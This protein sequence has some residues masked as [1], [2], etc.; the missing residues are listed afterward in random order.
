[1]AIEYLTKD[2]VAV[3]VKKTPRQARALMDKVGVT[4]ACGRVLVRRDALDR[5]LAEQND[6]KE[7]TK[8]LLEVPIKPK[9]DRYRRTGT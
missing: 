5:S 6:V 3:V 9:Y 2:E 1:M 7:S 8:P 4:H